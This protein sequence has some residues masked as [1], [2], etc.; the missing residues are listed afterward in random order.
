MD[1]EEMLALAR[2]QKAKG[3]EFVANKYSKGPRCGCFL[4][5]VADALGKWIADEFHP[6][7]AKVLGLDEYFVTGA[8]HGFDGLRRMDEYYR[9]EERKGRYNAGYALGQQARAEFLSP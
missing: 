5:A 2:V 3:W 4:G 7:A 9:S 8:A 1:G 6:T